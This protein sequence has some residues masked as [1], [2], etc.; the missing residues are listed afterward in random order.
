VPAWE[1]VTFFLLEGIAVEEVNTN[2]GIKE[3][4]AEIADRN[5][6]NEIRFIDAEAL[7]P[8]A[9]YAGR[10]PRDLMHE[11]KS[12]IVTSVYIGGFRLPELDLNL[13]GKMSRL[14]LS[15]FY[16]NVVEPLKPLKEYLISQGFA[17][18]IYDG[19]LES[20]CIPLKPAAVKAGLGWLGKN[21]LLINKKYGSF[22]ALGGIITNAELSQVY[23]IQENRC[24]SCNSCVDSCPSKA[25]CGSRLDRSSC[26]SNLLEEELWPDSIDEMKDNYFFECDI[27]QEAC[28]W[29]KNHLV[30]PLEK[31]NFLPAE[32]QKELTELFRFDRLMHMSEAEYRAEI[33]PLLTGVDLPY[34]LFQRNVQLA[35][36]NSHKKTQLAYNNRHKANP[37][38]L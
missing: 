27:C 29:N 18:E 6:I 23:P 33:L 35:Y 36:N 38:G 20:D 30:Q 12:L 26:L 9:L 13:H 15:G 19:L 32:R 2:Q 24:G 11:A 34:H 8:G 1:T 16:F 37:T 7:E 22:Q 5:G 21:T 28:P 25:V 31:G 4:L 17:A 10:Q 14:T 3:R